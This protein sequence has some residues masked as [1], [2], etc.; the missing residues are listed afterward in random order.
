MTGAYLNG[1]I[2]VKLCHGSGWKLW[3]F[4]SKKNYIVGKKDL[5]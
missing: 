5:Q 1:F 2:W 3:V 4:E